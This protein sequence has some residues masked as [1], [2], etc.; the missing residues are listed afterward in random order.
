MSP[1]DSPATPDL[2]GLQVEVR[3]SLLMIIPLW[4]AHAPQFG[5]LTAAVRRFQEHLRQATIAADERARLLQTKVEELEAQNLT[6]ALD[7]R[8]LEQENEALHQQLNAKSPWIAQL[9]RERNEALKEVKNAHK[10]IEDLLSRLKVRR[11]SAPARISQ[12]FS[13]PIIDYSRPLV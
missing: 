1:T 13:Y 11:S 2:T 6:Q 4:F 9:T 3:P 8:E 7:I 12:A 5:E 10:V